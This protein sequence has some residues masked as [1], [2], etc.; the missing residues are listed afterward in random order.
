MATVSFTKNIVIKEPESIERFIDIVSNKKPVYH[1]N[2]D[3]A[4]DKIMDRG[5]KIL[6][7]Y[8]SL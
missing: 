4:S 7:Q 3:L 5:K 1:V 8:L 6:K 2:K